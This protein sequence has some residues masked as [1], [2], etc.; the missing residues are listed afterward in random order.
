[1]SVSGISA[2]SQQIVQSLVN[3]RKQLDTLQQQ[4][5]TGQKSSDYAGL[6][7][8]TGLTV[9][10]RAQLSAID[11]YGQTIATVSTRLQVAQAALTSM[12]QISGTVLR[13]AAQS[14]TVTASGQSTEQG[15][16]GEQLDELVNALN[17]QVGDRYV[18][19]GR[20][21]TQPPVETTDHIINGDG[22]KAGLKQVI[23][24][25]AQADL[26]ASGLGRVVTGLSGNTVL[27]SEDVAGSPFGFK[28]AGV[29]S[30]IAGAT[31]SPPTGSPPS[32][33][34]TL[35]SVPNPGDTVAF[36]LDLPDGS[37]QTLTLTATADSPPAADQFTIG[38]DA[39]TTAA[40][41]QTA[42]NAGLGQLAQTSLTA[43]S[44]MAA[45]N[46]F[47]NIDA[48]HPPQRVDGPPF[49][50]ATALVDGT[51]NNTVT[52]YT[53][54]MS[55]DPR[56]TAVARVGASI[57]VSYGASANEQAL[58]SLVQNVATFAATSFSPTDPNTPVA[59]AALTSRVQSAL[60]GSPGTQK[61]DDIAAS[62]AN[63]QVTL[64]S[65]QDAHQQSSNVLNGLLDQITTVPSEQVG[66]E[67]LALQTQMQASLQTTAMMFKLNLADYL[68]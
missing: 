40:N 54:D 1:M 58:R 5:G 11:G 27:L 44:A 16:A 42:L 8:D 17:S 23:A 67:I 13:S 55:S 57:T 48:T 34:V 25:R 15:Q 9:G 26:G 31:V 22:G 33:S 65:V 4:L 45:S 52:W 10:L 68:G 38:A 19:G 20:D 2:A 30:N 39:P 56:T 53:G 41:L 64:Q 35:T 36:T 24:E 62:L 29:T 61:V 46:D 12:D 51:P 3:M 66:A 59:Y 47:F 63:A 60:A 32:T 28:L 49:D 7:S 18:F 50:T 43:A 21:V 37:Q 6:G 14:D